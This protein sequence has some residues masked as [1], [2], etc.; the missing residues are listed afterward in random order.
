MVVT[1]T[2]G[3]MRIVQWNGRTAIL[4]GLRNTKQNEDHCIEIHYQYQ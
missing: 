1:G 4:V 2:V 3:K